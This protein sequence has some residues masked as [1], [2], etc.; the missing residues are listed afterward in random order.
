MQLLGIAMMYLLAWIPYSTI[1]LIQMFQSSEQLAY[2]LSTYFAYVPYLQSLL[3][4][5]VCILFIPSIKEKFLAL[6]ATEHCCKRQFRHNRIATMEHSHRRTTFQPP[7][8]SLH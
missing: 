4:P 3:L 2:I 8:A 7:K 1:V 5:Y 6:F